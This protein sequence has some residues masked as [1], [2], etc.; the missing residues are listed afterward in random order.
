MN[1]RQAYLYLQKKHQDEIS[2][3]PI[4]YAFNDKQLEKALEKLWAKK[5]ECITVST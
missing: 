1:Y 2:N 3:F 4:A 5:E